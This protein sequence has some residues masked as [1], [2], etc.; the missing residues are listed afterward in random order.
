[1]NSRYQLMTSPVDSSGHSTGPATT[2][3]QIGLTYVR[4]MGV[5]TEKVTGSTVRL[6]F[7]VDLRFMKGEFVATDGRR[8]HGA[9]ALI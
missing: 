1:M 6:P 8:R 4:G 3:G 9:F 5:R 7:E 2:F